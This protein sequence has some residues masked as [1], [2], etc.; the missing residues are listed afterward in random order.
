MIGTGRLYSPLPISELLFERLIPINAGI[1]KLALYEFRYAVENL[2][3]REGWDSIVLDKQDEIERVISQ[4]SFYEAVMVKPREKDRIILDESIVR[5][6]RMLFVGLVR[7]E[8]S[9]SWVNKLFYFDIR[10][11]YFLPRTIY[12]TEAGLAHFG[13]KPFRNF[14][15]RQKQFDD[16]Q[17]IGYLEFQEANL[18]ID[19]A[20]IEMIQALIEVRGTPI[21]ITLAG[22]TAAGKTEIAERLLNTFEK[23]GR[24]V[25]TIEMDNFLL[26]RDF[27]DNKAMGKETTHFLLF[28]RSLE[29][30]LDGKKITIPR[31]DSSNAT[32]SHDPEG[33][34]K[35][36]C[37]PLGIEPADIIFL[38][39]NF[40]FQM[41]DIA[42][43]IGLKIVYLTDDPIR[44]KR[45]CKRDIDY[46]KNYDPA[47]FR[48]RFF[49]TQFMRADDIYRSL[50]ET[51]DMVVD[52]TGAALWVTPEIAKLLDG[53]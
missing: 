2:Y 45:K 8:Y 29:E 38:E 16:S 24:K 46:R 48:N 40:P 44:L 23:N 27:R 35:P 19:Q 6:T 18:E 50:M 20:F 15:P 17:D 39:G 28:K 26:D 14:E 25:T 49:K 37:L 52:T 1:K 7:G 11:F 5:L 21:L 36:G 43:L 12:F 30:I 13:G 3:P 42:G 51:C 53:N 34:L 22:P 31:Y 32:S 4:R 47:H 33:I 9:P 10:G 41:E